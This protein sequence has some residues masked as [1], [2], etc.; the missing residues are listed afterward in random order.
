MGTT[1]EFFHSEGNMPVEMEELKIIDKGS[2]IEG[3]VDFSISADMLSGPEEVSVE[4][5]EIKW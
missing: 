1:K 5:A 3:A 2:E 4:R